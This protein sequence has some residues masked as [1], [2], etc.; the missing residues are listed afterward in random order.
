MVE[1]LLAKEN[2]VGSNP[3]FR[4]VVTLPKGFRTVVGRIL[5]QALQWQYSPPAEYQGS[6]PC[7][8][9]DCIDLLGNTN[10]SFGGCFLLYN[11]HT[12][13]QQNEQSDN[14]LTMAESLATHRHYKGGY[15]RVIMVAECAETNAKIVVYQHLYPHAIKYWTRPLSAWNHPL[16]D[17]S[18]RFKPINGNIKPTDFDGLLSYE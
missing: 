6:I 14:V 13:T 4:S 15:Y 8:D 7:F 11:T 17:G 12:M 3:T 16:E 10:S 1:C 2:A 9:S 18:I 5:T